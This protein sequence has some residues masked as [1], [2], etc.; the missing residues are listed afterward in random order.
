MRLKY[1]L[2]VSSPPIL[3]EHA[4]EEQIYLTLNKLPKGKA[5]FYTIISKYNI[6]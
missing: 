1:D 4:F 3:V 5:S 2:I 6:E